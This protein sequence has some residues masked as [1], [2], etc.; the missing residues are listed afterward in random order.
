MRQKAKLA[1]GRF[2]GDPSYEFEHVEVKKIGEGD[3]QTEEEETVSIEHPWCLY[4]SGS[5]CSCPYGSSTLSHK[6][7]SPEQC[8]RM[9]RHQLNY[10]CLAL[11]I[12]IKEEDR[13]AAVIA[14]IETDARIVPRGSY[15]K[16]PTGQTYENRSFEGSC[17]GRSVHPPLSQFCKSDH[18]E[19]CGSEGS[20]FKMFWNFNIWYI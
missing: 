10:I 1:K 9:S 5:H 7:N 3:E 20:E 2:T 14:E 8:M 17:S 15:V 18:S 13:L 16:S 11:Q 6:N 4:C 19:P 12:I